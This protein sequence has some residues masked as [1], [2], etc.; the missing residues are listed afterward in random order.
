M[1]GRLREGPRGFQ[2]KAAMRAVHVV[3]LP[4]VLDEPI[5]PVASGIDVERLDPG[6]FQLGLQLSVD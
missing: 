5:P 2:R 6:I 3:F 4:P 1:T